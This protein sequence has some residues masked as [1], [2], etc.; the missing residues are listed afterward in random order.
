MAA[1]ACGTGYAAMPKTLMSFNVRNCSGMDNRRDIGRTASAILRFNPD[2]VAVQ[3]VDSLTGRSGMRYILGQ[4]ADSVG[5]TATFA[6]AI[7]YDGGRYGIGILSKEK[8]LRVNRRALPGREEERTMVI[9][10]FDSYI[11]A[12]VHLSLTPEDA[13]ASMPVIIEEA[14]RATKPFIIAGDMNSHPDSE[15]IRL[16]K[17]D[18]VILSDSATPTY[19]ASVPEEVLDYVAIYSKGASLPVSAVRAFVAEEPEASDH[20]PVVVEFIER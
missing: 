9:A 20:R 7:D 12:C 18:F 5:M 15:F 3:E 1:L 8:P 10:E 19:P 11:L 17:E 14:S 16:L 13:V 4:L 2:V 6:P